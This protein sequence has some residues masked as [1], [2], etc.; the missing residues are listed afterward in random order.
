MAYNVHTAKSLIS[1]TIIMVDI[2]HNDA[3]LYITVR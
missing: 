2:S 3:I 1:L